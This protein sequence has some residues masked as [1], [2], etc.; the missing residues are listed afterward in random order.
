MKVQEMKMV[1]DLILKRMIEANQHAL[2]SFWNMDRNFRGAA[3][4]LVVHKNMS[5]ADATHVIL[6]KRTLH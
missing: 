5:L 6:W 4:L 2:E 3:L 1:N